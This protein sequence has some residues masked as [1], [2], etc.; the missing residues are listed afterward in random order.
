MSRLK[1]WFWTKV[2]WLAYRNLIEK[3]I[4]PVG[5]PG[6]RDIE[7]RC[8][9]FDPRPVRFDPNPTCETDGHYLCEKC[10]HKARKPEYEDGYDV[11]S[12]YINILKKDLTL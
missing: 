8:D 2:L 10:C 11:F 3:G 1:H 9:A 12:K 4:C 7:F 5:V 6:V